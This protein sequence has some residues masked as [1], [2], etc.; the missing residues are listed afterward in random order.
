MTD[1]P[2]DYVA[3]QA[4]MNFTNAQ[5]ADALDISASFYSQLRRAG[6]GRKLYAWAAYG[7]QRAEMDQRGKG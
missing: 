3:W 2:F 6:I 4:Y 1:Q 7:M 5:A